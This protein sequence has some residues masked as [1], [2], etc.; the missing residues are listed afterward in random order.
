MSEPADRP[1]P[2][3]VSYSERVRIELRELITRAKSVGKGKEFLAAAKLLDE[4]LKIYPQ[5][6]Q[7][8]YD[9]QLE[10]ARIW[11]GVVPPLVA[12]YVLDEERRLVLVGMPIRP[13]PGTGL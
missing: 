3:R 10:P 13:L 5:F 7:P 12:Q 6:G 8:I 9:L 11:I 1:Q 2:Y 4:R